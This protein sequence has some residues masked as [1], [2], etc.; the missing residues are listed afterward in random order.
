MEN[1]QYCIVC[2]RKIV[3]SKRHKVSMYCGDICRK[4]ASR[5]AAKERYIAS[6]YNEHAKRSAEML[7]SCMEE[8]DSLGLT[9]GQY[10]ARRCRNG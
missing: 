9:Y 8:A 5:K 6:K 1:D 4:R 3:S 7:E 10:M 2:G